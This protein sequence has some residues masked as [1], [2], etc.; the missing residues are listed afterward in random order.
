M[1]EEGLSKIFIRHLVMAIP[2]SIAVLVVLI[3]AAVGIKQQV[4]ETMQYAARMGIYETG[5]FAFDYEV[6]TAVKKNVKEGIE[7]A[8]KT[9]KNELKVLLSD[10]Q[11][12]KDLKELIESRSE[13]S[14]ERSVEQSTEQST[15]EKL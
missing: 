3:I 5:N 4:K 2:W 13:V 14:S 1:K 12:K 6:V 10:P 7:F 15:Q 11:V 8:V 9:A